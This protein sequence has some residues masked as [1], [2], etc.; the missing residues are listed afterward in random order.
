MI[1]YVLFPY[2]DERGLHLV[3]KTRLPCFNINSSLLISVIINIC[4]L[5]IR[6]FTN[7][8]HETNCKHQFSPNMSSVR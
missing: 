8:Q 7:T 2:N 5:L 3:Q 1:K 6:V 4:I